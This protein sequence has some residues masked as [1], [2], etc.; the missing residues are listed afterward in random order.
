MRSSPEQGIIPDFRI[1]NF[2]PVPPFDPKSLWLLQCSR[3]LLHWGRM[4]S[5]H[6]TGT[7]YIE[8]DE[9]H[10]SR[11]RRTDAHLKSVAT[12]RRRLTSLF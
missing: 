5:D 6:F 9:T 3:V 10:Y 7:D 11:K 8:Y 12:I 2:A 1:G 4:L